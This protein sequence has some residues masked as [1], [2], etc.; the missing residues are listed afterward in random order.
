M[1]SDIILVRPSGVLTPPNDPQ[2]LSPKP[3]NSLVTLLYLI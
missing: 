1:E 3:S 2:L